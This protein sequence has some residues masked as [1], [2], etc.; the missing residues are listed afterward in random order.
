MQ[1]TTET[2][3]TNYAELF[4]SI[5]LDEMDKVK[6]MNRTDK[7]YWFHINRLQPLLEAVKENYFVLTMC[8][9]VALP[10]STIYYDTESNGMYTAH[11]NGKLNRFKIRRRIYLLNGISF[12]EV[13]FKNNKGRTI[14]KRIPSNFVSDGFDES[15]NTF[16]QKNTPF[17][18]AELTPRLVNSFSRITLVNRNFNERCTIDFNLNFQYNNNQIS[19]TDL[20]IVEIKADGSSAESPLAKALRDQRINASGF[21][22]YCVGRLET[23]PTLKYN[24]FKNKI[25]MIE[26]AINLKHNMYNI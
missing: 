21:S 4:P 22:K 11:H 24:A 2:G 25:R 23:D 12:L 20:V 19:L 15:E 10:Y 13:K 14:K 7:K 6:L 17:T 3:T 18:S 5:S 16:L 9:E 1:R 26:K 8:N